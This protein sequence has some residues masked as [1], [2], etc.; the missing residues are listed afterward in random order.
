MVAGAGV[1]VLVPLG[2]HEEGVP[3][4]RQVGV[5]PGG[6]DVTLGHQLVD[7]PYLHAETDLDRVD[8][9]VIARRT[10]AALEELGEAL[11]EGH[12]AA[13]ERHLDHVRRDGRTGQDVPLPHPLQD[14]EP[15]LRVQRFAE[16][17]AGQPVR[18]RQPRERVDAVDP[19][20]GDDQL[21]RRL[22]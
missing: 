7:T 4:D 6:L 10:A 5:A 21:L 13:L 2:D 20:A 9:A 3:L 15:D 12:A 14:Q 11:L 1:E 8:A 18:H 19:G 22:Q 17:G 16:A